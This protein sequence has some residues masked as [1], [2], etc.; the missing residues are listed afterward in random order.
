MESLNTKEFLEKLKTNNLK[1]A[2]VLKGFVKASDDDSEILFTQKWNR[3][4]NVSIPTSMIESV[5]V[6]KSILD[7]EEPSAFVKL[8][9]KVPANPEAKTLYKLL[10]SQNEN[11]ISVGCKCGMKKEMQFNIWDHPKYAA[12]LNSGRNCPSCQ[13]NCP[14]GYMKTG[15][16]DYHNGGTF[17]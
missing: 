8:F 4:N 12:S 16:I 10:M 3:L 6:L 13:H 2:F 1:S 17:M 7:K 11:E 14:C 5:V 15:H 9:L